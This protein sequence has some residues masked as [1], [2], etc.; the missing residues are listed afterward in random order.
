MAI[1]T[2]IKRYS[3]LNVGSPVVFPLFIPDGVVGINDRFHLLNLYAIIS[4]PPSITS[5]AITISTEDVLY[6]YQ[7]ITTDAD[8]DATFTYSLII[9]PTGMTIGTS[10]GLVSWTPVNDDVG[11]NSVTVRVTDDTGL[12]DQQSYTLA[13]AN[14]NDVPV[15][16]STPIETASS[17]VLYQYTVTAT[18]VDVG[19]LLTYSLL[20]PPFGMFIDPGTGI[21]SWTPDNGDAGTHSI[22]VRAT[23]IAGL[24][25]TQTFNL[26]VGGVTAMVS[27]DNSPPT[28]Y[29]G[30][31]YVGDL[32][33]V[34]P[35]GTAIVSLNNLSGIG[36]DALQ[37]VTATFDQAVLNNNFKDCT[38]KIEEVLAALRT[39]GLIAI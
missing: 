30:P 4:N 25:D 19:D 37:D 1:D 28:H 5:T 15:I 39:H 38:D 29:A 10:T 34:G 20:A 8:L 9:Y 35:Q 2:P 31:L 14:V 36:T 23:D 18:D 22:S 26:T 11:N 33:V 13:V 21:V 24:Y 16:T 7:I 27:M 12:Y 6:Q 17:S 3:M 32:K